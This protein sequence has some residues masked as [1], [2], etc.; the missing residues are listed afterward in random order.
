MAALLPL[1][2]AHKL[3]AQVQTAPASKG[4]ELIKLPY[5]S[6]ALEPII[7]KRTVELHHGKHLAGY[8]AK[9]NSLVQKAGMQGTDLVQLVRYSSGAL[10]DNAGQLLNHNLYFQQFRPARAEAAKPVGVLAKAIERSYGSFER[11]Q[12]KFEQAGLS[13]FGSGWL[14]LACDAEGKLYIDKEANAGN[15]V[16]QNLIPLLGI[17][18]WEHAYYLDYEN[19][20]ADHLKQ[21]WRIINW[22]VVGKR[23]DERSKGIAT[24]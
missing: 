8:V 11:F 1:A 19:R 15:P 5:A 16:V 12:E 10:F 2:T 20:R 24:R 6:D 7:S 3:S 9:L 23:Y 21:I 14:W 18:I 17:D 13:I 4:F 22:E